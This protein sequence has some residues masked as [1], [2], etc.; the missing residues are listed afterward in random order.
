MFDLEMGEHGFLSITRRDTSVMLI[1]C[2]R[3]ASVWEGDAAR[4]ELK[5]YF[6]A[7][8][9]EVEGSWGALPPVWNSRD[10][11]YVRGE[12]K[13]FHFTTLQMQ[14]WR[15]FPDDIIYKENPHGALWYSLE[16]DADAKGY[17]VFTRQ[18]PSERYRRNLELYRELHTRGAGD[19]GLA[20]AETFDGHSLPRHSAAIGEMIAACNAR[21]VLDYGCGKGSK[22][23]PGPEGSPLHIRSMKPWGDVRVRLYDPGHEAYAQLPEDK[24]DGVLCTDVLE[25]IPEEDIPWII[26]ELFAHASRFVYAAVAC[27][28]ARKTLAD[29]QNAHCTVRDIEWWREHFGAAAARHPGV[30]WELHARQ[31]GAL[32]KYYE[33]CSGDAAAACEAS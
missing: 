24:F 8:A 28:A 26:E 12:S 23:G 29:G 6:R 4:Q 3:M 1:D 11:E 13:L 22:Y 7:R 10:H 20:P 25:H 14:P 30:R 33:T 5:K 21:T 27:Y 19:L 17:Q 18:R 2:A 32:R 16:R 9:L 15:P 31:K